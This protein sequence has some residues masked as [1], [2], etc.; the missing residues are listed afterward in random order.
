MASVTSFDSKS[1][2]KKS[3]NRIV[4]PSGIVRTYTGIGRKRL[5]PSASEF[6]VGR[7]AKF[8]PVS[9]LSNYSDHPDRRQFTGGKAKD[10]K[11]ESSKK[12]TL[13]RRQA[14]VLVKQIAS[15]CEKAYRR[16]V[17]QAVAV[18]PSPEDAS[19]YRYHCVDRFR[20]QAFHLIAHRMPEPFT[21]EQTKNWPKA[22]RHTG[23]TPGVAMHEV[24]SRPPFPSIDLITG[25]TPRLTPSFMI[26]P[27][28]PALN[29]IYPDHP[30]PPGGYPAEK[31]K[32]ENRKRGTRPRRNAYR[33]S[34]LAVRSQRTR[35]AILFSSRKFARH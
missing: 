10:M 22:A 32:D 35:R 33:R 14:R 25:I 26:L 18:K 16:G 1:F 20:G 8:E 9:R 34:N 6:R 24:A 30:D 12:M 23:T 11:T 19:W 28:S 21:A 27:C 5:R 15:L 13:S 31:A 29:E 7:F 3:S 4:R 2:E 17:E